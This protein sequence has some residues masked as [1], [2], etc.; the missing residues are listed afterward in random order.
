MRGIDLILS[1]AKRK[2][3][4]FPRISNDFLN[5]LIKLTG[6]YLE[7][8][9]LS[10]GQITAKNLIWISA[11]N[12]FV[13][14]EDIC[15][16]QEPH[17]HLPRTQGSSL[18]FHWGSP[19]RWWW[20][21]LCPSLSGGPGRRGT[22]PAS[23]HPETAAACRTAGAHG[24]QCRDTV[25]HKLASWGQIN[26]EDESEAWNVQDAWICVLLPECVNVQV[27]YVSRRG[28]SCNGAAC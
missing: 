5:S 17:P 13:Q 24:N 8:I 11:W 4:G 3:S 19:P 23:A 28:V 22:A 27:R 2:I 10:H 14:A 1:S 12:H 9:Y 20:C 7:N 21:S 15:N 26:T 25:I 16:S 6:S 18:R